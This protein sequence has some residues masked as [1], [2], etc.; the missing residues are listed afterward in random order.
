MGTATLE[1]HT[2]PLTGRHLI[3]AS[4]GT[5][6]TF[7]ITRLYLRLLI[8]KKLD[9]QHILVMT[10]T[11]AA[12]EELRGR[13][14]QTLRQAE[15]EWGTLGE[16]DPFFHSLEQ[17]YSKESV[18]LLLRNALLHLDE[19]AIFTIHGFCARV[20]KQHAF[21]SDVSLD[22]DME[23]DT[24][25]L[26]LE[27]L[28][29]WFRTIAHDESYQQLM[30]M[31][32][33]TPEKFWE[34]FS[35]AIKSHHELLAISQET[36]TQHWINKKSALKQDLL[37]QEDFILDTL[38][39]AHKQKAIRLEEWATLL[40]WL[41]T[42]DFSAPPKTAMAFV[43]GNRYRGKYALKTLFQPF[44]ALKQQASIE[45]NLA[46]SAA[47]C[48]IARQGIEH[49]RKTFAREKEKQRVM[50]FDDLIS[51]LADRLQ[52]DTAAP[53]IAALQAQYPAALVDEFQDTD[54]QQYAILDQ[55]YPAR[56]PELA[57][58][59]I[60][61][62]KQAIYAFRGGDVFAYLQARK[63]ADAC[64]HMGTNWRSV[65]DMVNGYNRLFWGAARDERARA[66]F[67]F[68]IQYEPIQSTPLAHANQAPLQDQEKNRKA[69]NYVWITPEEAEQPSVNADFRAV[70]ARWCSHEIQR[71][72]STQVKL[73][74]APLQEQD[75]AI[76]V[77]SKIEATEIRSELT[78]TGL[79]SVYLSAR[80]NVFSS[81]QAHELLMVL[82][83]ILDCEDP[84]RLMAAYS[85][86]LMGGDAQ[87]L[88][89]RVDHSDLLAETRYHLIR[90]REQW[91]EQG[92]MPMMMALLH[93]HLKPLPEQHERTLTNYLHL[94][95]LLQKATGNLR[96]PQQLIEW[97]ESRVA[98]EVMD[99]EAELRLESD[100]NLIRVIT[101]HGAKGLEYP[102]V[103]IPYS[104]YGKNPIKYKQAFIDYYQYHDPD[105]LNPLQMIGQDP[106]AQQLCQREGFAETIRLLYVAITRAEHRCYVCAAPF[107]NSADSPLAKTLNLTQT[108]DWLTALKG[109]TEN[110]DDGSQLIEFS[111]TE[112]DQRPKRPRLATD[113]LLKP[114]IFHGKIDKSWYLSSFSALTRNLSHTR[115]DK[116]DHHDDLPEPT[117]LQETELS[118]LRFSLA[119]GAHT[120]N[121]LHDALEH[122]DFTQPDWPAVLQDPLLHYPPLPEQQVS[123]LTHWLQACIETELPA[124][125]PC[126]SGPALCDLERKS[127]LRESE[128]YFPLNA[129]KMGTLKEI[130]Q[131]HR[132][133]ETTVTLP[134]ATTL[135][136]MMHGFI[137][138]IF[139]YQGRFYVA[140]YKSTHL[141]NHASDYDL[142]ALKANNEA[143]FYDLQY[144][145]YSLALHRYLQ[146]R[147]ADYHPAEHFGGV[148]YLYLRGMKPGADSGIF[149][150]AIDPELLQALDPL[151]DGETLNDQSVFA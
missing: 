14:D 67:D 72:L 109:L 116:K 130:L 114:C 90:L 70:I 22:I 34:K 149:H 107:R 100:A 74:E 137:D 82:K 58:F 32:W 62:P 94:A 95:E 96:H 150:T 128:F 29:D 151:F 79:A 40:A 104:N 99:Q 54:R 86:R 105:T 59:M 31:G 91:H 71:L 111:E 38:V 33:H 112:F 110:P 45:E 144:L 135:H 5:G 17:K 113:E 43:N 6:K 106:E 61:D 46:T 124:I 42:E 125:P 13:I 44:K 68:G 24:G 53:L 65:P 126:S 123:E 51:V 136:G 21:S 132:Q 142:A 27:G 140:D 3:E 28:R 11:R 60:G 47:A 23:A 55:L 26:A 30:T 39:N 75:I 52:S 73:G 119:K 88:A 20:L 138:L 148:Y 69:L 145:I 81:E 141:G 85:T 10:F 133:S 121:L 103:F 12:T 117:H 102:V 115:P 89:D 146:S 120:G 35:T 134:T 41:D 87:Q 129:A 78:A 84:R 8:E 147:I 18:G 143:H 19:A 63:A 7:N 9:V 101:Q 92:F 108:E 64:W 56:H 80:D 48:Q 25:E 50:D 36:V 127:T 49:V 66:V 4:A 98:L 83:G 76:L 139:E 1:P 122:C 37:A 2:I 57:L 97:L 93:T 131:T 15:S 77:R 16:H 118:E